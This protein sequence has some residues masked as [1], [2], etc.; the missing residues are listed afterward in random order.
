MLYNVEEWYLFEDSGRRITAS[1]R[2][3]DGFDSV[4]QARE[5]QNVNGTGFSELV[6]L[7]E[8]TGLVFLLKVK[9]KVE[10]RKEGK[11]FKDCE[12]SKTVH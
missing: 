12:V 5:E 10:S 11:P 3:C 1:C 4:A 8:K 9:E 7:D 2:Y 6:S